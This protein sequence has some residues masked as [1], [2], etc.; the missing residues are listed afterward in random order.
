MKPKDGKKYL[1]ENQHD[2]FVH[3][4]DITIGGNLSTKI[5]VDVTD[6][7]FVEK[8]SKY[9]IPDTILIKTKK[10]L[11]ASVENVTIREPDGQG[12]FTC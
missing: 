11:P 8:I 12:D 2:T 3:G 9:G 7:S 10:P 6:A 4:G 1:S 5:M